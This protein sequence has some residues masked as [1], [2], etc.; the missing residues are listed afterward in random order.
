MALPIDVSIHLVF[1]VSQLK[2]VIG[3]QVTS[4]PLLLC[5]ND[6]VELQVFP[7]EVLPIRGNTPNSLK[8]LISWEGLPLGDSSW[9]SYSAITS[10]FP[11]FHLEDKVKVLGDY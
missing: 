9:E 11:T 3:L 2:K 5:L 1:H 8:I 4:Q 7:E 10:S 6:D